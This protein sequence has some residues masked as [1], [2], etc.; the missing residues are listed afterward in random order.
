MAQLLFTF[1]VN[2][3]LQLASGS[4]TLYSECLRKNL[5]RNSFAERR[6]RKLYFQ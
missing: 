6:Q 3:S 2:D 4:L 5:Q 1:S